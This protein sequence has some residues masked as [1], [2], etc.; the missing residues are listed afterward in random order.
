MNLPAIMKH[1]EKFVTDN[2]PTILTALGV[3]GTVTTA[4]FTGQAVIKAMRVLEEE[5]QAVGVDLAPLTKEDVK[6]VWKLFIPAAVSGAF[7]IACII[8]ANR[9]GTRRAA[10]LATAYSLSEK[11]FVEYREKI[12][13]KLG[14]KKE[15]QVRHE[16]AQDR[17]TRTPG[18]NEVIIASNKVLCFDEYSGRYFES[19][20]ETLRRAQNDVNEQVLQNGS[21]SL[22]DFYKAIGLAPTKYSHEI[23]WNSTWTPSHCCDLKFSA[24]LSEDGR[25]CIAI[26]H[27]FVPVRDYI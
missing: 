27:L 10:A 18:S 1:V 23:G 17:V 15:E 12:V 11:A 25:P 26:D 3:T 2:S 6:L 14:E 5:H 7:S 9:I 8:G 13:E 4:L 19:D 22:F 21:A 16:L 20:M 24:V